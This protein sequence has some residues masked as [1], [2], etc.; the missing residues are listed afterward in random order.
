MF[1][2]A[3][4]V[5]AWLGWR[6]YQSTFA[7]L[8]HLRANMDTLIALGTTAAFLFSFTV[9]FF[10]NIFLS[11]GL[12][13][14]V[15]YD[16]SAVIL[17][18]VIL[19]KYLE[20]RAK[21]RTGDAISALLNLQPP[22]ARVLRDGKEVDVPLMEVKIGDQLRVRPGEKIAVDGVILEGGSSLDE[23][24]ITGE[25]LP[26][27]KSPGDKVIGG[28][29][30]KN[31]SFIFRAAAV[32]QATVLARIVA[33]VR[34]A[35][36]SKA[37]VQKLAD[38]ISAY[39]VPAVL[40]I[41]VAA[42]IFWFLLGPYPSLTYALTVFVTVLIIA[43][44][45]ALGLATPTAIVVGIGRGASKGILIRDAESLERATKVSMVVFD[46]TGTLTYGKP[47]VTDVVPS[48][49]LPVTADFVLQTAG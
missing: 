16:T 8:R 25:S 14:E 35:Q 30:N 4:P 36:A 42:G 39:F 33:M 17:T 31:G 37:P 49:L 2:F 13:A 27:D 48:P 23:S 45:C 10:P 18:L 38:E 26:I 19:G 41:A 24:M 47:K 11:A 28:T 34:Q 40:A 21:T 5:Q 44:P 22:V 3:L 43:C 15:Y 32:G 46:K 29:L 7:A 9:T 6:F 1:A 20:A 12:M